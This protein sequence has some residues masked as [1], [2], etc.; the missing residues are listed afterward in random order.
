[1]HALGSVWSGLVWVSRIYWL[2]P[3]PPRVSSYVLLEVCEPMSVAACSAVSFHASAALDG[4]LLVAGD[5]G[6]MVVIDTDTVMYLASI[7]AENTD[8]P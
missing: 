1:M 5:L 2:T 6:G 3:G 4:R 8:A 7:F